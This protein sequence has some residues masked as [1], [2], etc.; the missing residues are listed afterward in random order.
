[1]LAESVTHL[2]AAMAV[3]LICSSDGTVSFRLVDQVARKK[4]KGRIAA[5]MVY[6][7]GF[8]KSVVGILINYTNNG[9]EKYSPLLACREYNC[10][11]IWL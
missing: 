3:K 10:Y 2:I 7:Q 8:S 6:L 1:M 5:G 4:N 9:S 11:Q